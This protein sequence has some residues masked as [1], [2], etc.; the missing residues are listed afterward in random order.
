MGGYG[1]GRHN[2]YNSKTTV[3]DCRVLNVNKLARDGMIAPTAWQRSLVWRN[4]DTGEQV[5]AVDYT[6]V[7]SGE[8][9]VFT[10]IYTVTHSDGEKHDVREPV[11][12]QV[13]HP[14]LGGKR[15]WFTC[16]LVI[17]G[18]ECNRRVGKL[19]L[20]P[21]GLYFGCRHCYDLTYTSCQESHKC[22]GLYRLLAAQ[23]GSSPEFVK[24]ILNEDR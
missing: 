24:R 8:G 3:E 20:P 7:G 2:S 16:P 9:L 10:L 11:Q 21:G 4:T 1:S 15:W 19:Y 5:A 13:T 18:R 6:C 12:L 22:D 14:R 17:R 23:T